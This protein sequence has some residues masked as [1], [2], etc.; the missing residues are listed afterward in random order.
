MLVGWKAIRQGYWWVRNYDATQGFIGCGT[1]LVFIFFGAIFVFLSL[2]PW[3]KP[4]LKPKSKDD[5]YKVP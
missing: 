5:I 4:D 1:T 2:I 3:P